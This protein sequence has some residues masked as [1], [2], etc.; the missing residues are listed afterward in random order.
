MAIKVIRAEVADAVHQTVNKE[1]EAMAVE[2]IIN[3]II[4]NIINMNTI[5]ISI[6]QIN[7]RIHTSTILRKL[8]MVVTVL[9][10][11]RCHHNREITTKVTIIN[12]TIAD[13]VGDTMVSR[14][15]ISDTIMDLTIIIKLK[16]NSHPR[17]KETC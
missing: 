9:S 8:V 3:N 17:M 1:A 2:I 7:H 11:H 10:V 5:S 13:A 15:P 14:I 6:R 16:H 12:I 4:N